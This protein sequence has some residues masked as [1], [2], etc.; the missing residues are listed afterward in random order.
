MGRGAGSNCEEKKLAAIEV[1][2]VGHA[3]WR[4]S[5]Q[6]A[7]FCLENAAKSS[8]LELLEASG[9]PN[10]LDESIVGSGELELCKLRL[11]RL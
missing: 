1:A 10:G 4:R 7:F 3:R 6:M 2:L 9:H 11:D 5:S 8:D